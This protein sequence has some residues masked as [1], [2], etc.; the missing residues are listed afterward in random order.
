MPEYLRDGNTWEQFSRYASCQEEKDYYS[1][2][3]YPN[4]VPGKQWG[5]AGSQQVFDQFAHVDY[6]QEAKQD[7]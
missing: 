1:E 7:G 2:Q 5:K 6:Q 4:D 3:G